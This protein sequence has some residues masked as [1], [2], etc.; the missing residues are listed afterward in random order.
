MTECQYRCLTCLE[1]TVPRGF[2]VSHLSLTCEAC[3]EFGRFINDRVYDQFLAFED[4][5]PE[6][7]EWE[8]FERTEKLMLSQQVTRTTRSVEDFEI[9]D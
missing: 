9:T 7:L 8:R 1:H 2:D 5:P 4:D 6:S 3:G